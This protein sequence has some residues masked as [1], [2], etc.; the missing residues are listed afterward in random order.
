MTERQ[1]LGIG[2]VNVWAPCCAYARD[3]RTI[4]VAGRHRDGRSGI[5]AIPVAGGAGRPVLVLDPALEFGSF[6]VRGDRLYL[7]VGEPQ[8]NVW[9]AKLH[10]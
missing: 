9:V 3:G 7:A 1:R 2:L 10:W 8:S 6:S 4:Y 5:W